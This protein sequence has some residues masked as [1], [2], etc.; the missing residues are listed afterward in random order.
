[1]QSILYICRSK[2]YCQISCISQYRILSL[3][4]AR[5]E[6]VNANAFIM[7]AIKAFSMDF[8]SLEA[9]IHFLIQTSFQMYYYVCFN[10]LLRAIICSET[11]TN[12]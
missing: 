2:E 12:A 10:G 8:N 4:F 9:P 3:G 11:I 1:M 6:F 5:V 7:N